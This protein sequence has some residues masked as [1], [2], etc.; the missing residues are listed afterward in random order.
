MATDILKTSEIPLARL[1]QTLKHIGSSPYRNT[2][3]LS[4]VH[5]PADSPLWELTLG[6]LLDYQALR[7]RDAK[8]LIIP[9]TNTRWTYGELQ[10]E[11]QR[12]ARGLLAK[13][14]QPGDRIGI[15]AG[16]CEQ[17]VSLFFA[18]MYVGAILVVINNTYTPSEL[19]YA[20]EHS[21]ENLIFLLFFFFVAAQ[22]G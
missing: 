1:R 2:T 10:A 22:L 8:C 19:M 16:N 11:S 17:Y 20:L 13:G 6:E 12:L 7:F 21:G 3:E 9:W 18:A 15:M 5:G 4:I 14:I